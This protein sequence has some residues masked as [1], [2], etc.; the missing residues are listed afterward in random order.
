MEYNHDVVMYLLH[1]I[2]FARIAQI[3]NK[4]ARRDNPSQGTSHIHRGPWTLDPGW[5]E[6]LEPH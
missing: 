3:Y 1:Y 2:R 6:G 5:E 4:L